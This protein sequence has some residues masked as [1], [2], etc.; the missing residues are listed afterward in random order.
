MAV[1]RRRLLAGA[2][3][4]LAAAWGVGSY[5]W[6]AAVALTDGYA[7]LNEDADPPF[8]ELGCIVVNDAT[9]RAAATATLELELP[10]GTTRSA[11]ERVAPFGRDS[12]QALATFEFPDRP[13]DELADGTARFAIEDCRRR[14]LVPPLAIGCGRSDVTTPVE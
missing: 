12:D 1:T 10:D 4:G 7:L 3:G 2:A 9:V 11:T 5:A 14:G 13:V 8:V 6:R